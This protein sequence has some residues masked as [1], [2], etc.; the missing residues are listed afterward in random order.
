MG[1]DPSSLQGKGVTTR[2]TTTAAAIHQATYAKAVYSGPKKTP[3]AP[4]AMATAPAPPNAN[5]KK[6]P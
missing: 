2:S 1:P 3:A 6:K 5:Q 4:G